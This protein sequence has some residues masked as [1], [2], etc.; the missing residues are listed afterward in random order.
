VTPGDAQLAFTFYMDCA[1][2][3]PAFSEYCAADFCGSGTVQ[4]CDGSV[5]PAD[6][7]GIMRTY[8]MMPDPC[9]K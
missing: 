3:D 9:E 5:T 2:Q 8:L 7:L 1:G 4:P 6:A